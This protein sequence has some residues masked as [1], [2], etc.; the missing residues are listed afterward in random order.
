MRKQYIIEGSVKQTLVNRYERDRSARDKCIEH[1]GLRCSICDFDFEETYGEVGAGFI[2]VHHLVQ[3]SDIKQEYQIDPINDL[4]PVCPNCHAM[5]HKK[6]PPYSID[7]L[8]AHMK[9]KV[10]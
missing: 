8:K 2:H 3:I 9:K 10:K 4:R 6:N 1:Y 5:L 7:E